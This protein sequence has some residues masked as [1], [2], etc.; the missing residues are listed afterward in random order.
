MSGGQA[1]IGSRL[2]NVLCFVIPVTTAFRNRPT[3][4]G[5]TYPEACEFKSRPTVL[6]RTYPEAHE[7]SGS[8][9]MTVC[10][11]DGNQWSYQYCR[12]QW[13]LADTEHLRYKYLQA[14][15]T[16][17]QHLDQDFGFLSSSH[18]NVSFQ[19]KEEEQVGR[20]SGL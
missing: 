1:S 4:L 20:R 17:L 16:A 9:G 8:S 13:S 14:W 18:Q 10:L 19:G 12:R 3:V 2:R 7:C 15:D 6:G 5:R 11:R